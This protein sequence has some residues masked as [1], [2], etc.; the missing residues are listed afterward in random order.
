MKKLLLIASLC[1]LASAPTSFAQSQ[2]AVFEIQN[3]TREIKR[4][5][6]VATNLKLSAETEDSFWEQYD[7]YRADVKRLEKARFG[8]IQ[9][10]AKNFA[11]L[12]EKEA[13]SLVKRASDLEVK[14]AKR[15]QV[16]MDKLEDALGGVTAFQYYQI[17]T[18][19]DALFEAELTSQIPLVMTESQRPV[20][21]ERK[22]KEKT[23]KEISQ[24][25]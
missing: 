12:S 6:V 9:E 19:L 15:K 5:A 4:R 18:K 24:L 13:R 25:D 8:L 20:R 10:L 3:Q 11:D 7:D 17:E 2:T 16:Q 1:F 21:V 14:T 22:P 23:L